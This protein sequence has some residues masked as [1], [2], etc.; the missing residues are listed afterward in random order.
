MVLVLLSWLLW[1][2]LFWP[3]G[4]AVCLSIVGRQHSDLS[5]TEVIMLGMS[6]VAFEAILFSCFTPLG[7]TFKALIF[8]QSVVCFLVFNLRKEIR[9]AQPNWKDWPWLT[10]V[11]VFGFGLLM[12]AAAPIGS[13]DAGLYYRPS[14][15]WLSSYGLVPGLGNLHGR[16]AFNSAWHIL[17]AGVQIPLGTGIYLEDLNEYLTLLLVFFIAQSLRRDQKGA[18]EWLL[19]LI[20][21]PLLIVQFLSAPAPDLPIYVCTLLILLRLGK[22]LRGGEVGKGAILFIVWIGAFMLFIKLSSLCI[23][24]L[25]LGILMQ[26]WKEHRQQTWARMVIPILVVGI[27]WV[28]RFY[29]MTGYLAYPLP[30]KLLSIG[31]P[32]WT[33]P[34]ELVKAEV[35]DVEGF[36]KVPMAAVPPIEMSLAE[37][38]AKPMKSWIR[39]WSAARTWTDIALLVAYAISL[40]SVC[41]RLARLIMNDR[42]KWLAIATL[43]YLVTSL[44]LWFL[45][46]PDPRFFIGQLV[47]VPLLVACIG[48]LKTSERVGVLVASMSSLCFCFLALDMRSVREHLFTPASYGP[49]KVK[50]LKVGNIQILVPL[51][52]VEGGWETRCYDAPLPCTFETK[53]ELEKLEMRGKSLSEG[54]RTRQKK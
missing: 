42:Y 31:Q 9:I 8:T 19:V 15:N 39:Y 40:I 47:G 5:T 21:T 25:L 14:I 29:T 22:I 17:V 52:M 2:I 12:K 24:L 11:F 30:A 36:A 3:L 46:A 26:F 7:F 18:M 23:A 10:V 44:G 50:E 35:E 38:A 37:R 45:K 1:T 43:I 27:A 54:F 16:L 53:E 4:K 13:F 49:A 32:D 34:I 20:A 33:V 51:P 6:L 41:A 48:R 28:F